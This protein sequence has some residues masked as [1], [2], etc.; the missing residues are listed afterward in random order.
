VANP[1]TNEALKFSSSFNR[2]SVSEQ[3]FAMMN[4]QLKE[5]YE[6]QNYGDDTQ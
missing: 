1:K 2:A 3:F 5:A 6:N 4:R